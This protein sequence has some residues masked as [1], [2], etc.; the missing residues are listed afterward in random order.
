MFDASE[1]QSGFY[2]YALQAGDFREMKE[3]LLIK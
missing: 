1:L 3:M 2:L